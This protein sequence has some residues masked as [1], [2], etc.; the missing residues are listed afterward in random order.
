[1]PVLIDTAHC[2]AHAAKSRYVAP[3]STLSDADRIEAL[4]NDPE[5]DVNGAPM[6]TP[7]RAAC[8]PPPDGALAAGADMLGNTALMLACKSKNM[9][10]AR[11]LLAHPRIELDLQNRRGFTALMF[12]TCKGHAA[13]VDLLLAAGADIT[14]R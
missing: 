5:Q 10:L 9:Q 3:L 4:L 8:P 13:M 1:M 7:R 12:A 11:M 2:R 14:V 6:H